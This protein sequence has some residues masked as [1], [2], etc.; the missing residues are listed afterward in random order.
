MVTQELT[1]EHECKTHVKRL[2]VA[3]RAWHDVPAIT[4]RRILGMRPTG[5]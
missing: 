1:L 5:L 4:Q 3:F 2:S